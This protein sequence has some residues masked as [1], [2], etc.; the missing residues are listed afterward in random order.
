MRSPSNAAQTVIAVGNVGWNSQPRVETP[1]C[2]SFCHSRVG[3]ASWPTMVMIRVGVPRWDATKAV[4]A[5]PPPGKRAKLVVL[6]SSPNRGTLGRSYS[7]KSRK[8]SPK[9]AS[10]LS[11]GALAGVI[12]SQIIAELRTGTKRLAE[13]TE[14]LWCQCLQGFWRFDELFKRREPPLFEGPPR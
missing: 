6:T 10:P 11:F 2:S 13:N 8:N 12:T 4:V 5:R 7:T 9:T 3:S 1:L 14:S